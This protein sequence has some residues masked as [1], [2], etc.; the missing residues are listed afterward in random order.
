MQ[1]YV[2]NISIIGFAENIE[3]PNS[4]MGGEILS[5]SQII[6]KLEDISC[7]SFLWVLRAALAAYL[8]L[9]PYTLHL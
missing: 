2:S 8:T 6:S 5:L 4:R 9:R 3:T 1:F 7:K